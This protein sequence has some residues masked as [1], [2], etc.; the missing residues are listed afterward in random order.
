[1][2]EEYF[3][4]LVY[5]T[6]DVD[7]LLITGVRDN[8]LLAGFSHL[9]AESR[10][11]EVYIQASEQK[12]K[13]CKGYNNSSSDGTDRHDSNN[14]NARANITT[15]DYCPSLIFDNNTTGNKAAQKFI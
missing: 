7:V 11:I 13:S 8:A 5:S 14:S 6:V 3:L 15:L 12:R 4:E 1:M 9:V 2:P 10:L